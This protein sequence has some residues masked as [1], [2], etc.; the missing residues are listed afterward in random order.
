MTVFEA[1]DYRTFIRDYSIQNKDGKRGFYNRMAK[2]LGT[3]PSLVTQVMKEQRDF[4][5]DMTVQ[6]IQFFGLSEPEGEHFVL[7][8][9]H[10]KAGTG[11]VKKY[12]EKKIAASKKKASD[13]SHRTGAQKVLT[14]PQRAIFYSDWYY[15]AIRLLTSLNSIHSPQDIARALELP[16]ELVHN[17]LDFLLKND[18]VIQSPSGLELGPLRTHIPQDSE[19]VARHHKNWRSHLLDR[20]HVRSQNEFIFTGPT[21]LSQDD[22]KTVAEKLRAFITELAKL[23]DQSKPEVFYCLNIDWLKVSEVR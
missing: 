1:L 18:L 16:I 4:T 6:L 17:V 2:F 8:V 12:F 20:S 10:A 19:F 15:S 13:L 3:A 9:Q 14:T 7:L 21:T 5:L 23:H 11:E 22:A